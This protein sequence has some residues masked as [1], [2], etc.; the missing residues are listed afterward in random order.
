MSTCGLTPLFSASLSITASTTKHIHHQKRLKVNLQLFL[1]L[2]SL[3]IDRPDSSSLLLQSKQ[4]ICQNHNLLDRRW[5]GA[6]VD[7]VI[8]D[9]VGLEVAPNHLLLSPVSSLGGLAAIVGSTADLSIVFPLIISGMRA[10][11]KTFS[12]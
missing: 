5:L 6:P 12:D 8:V 2:P 10:E 4:H 9:L 1:D 11:L 3:E 7:D